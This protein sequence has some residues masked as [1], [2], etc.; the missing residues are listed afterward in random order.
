MRNSNVE[1]CCLTPLPKPSSLHIQSC[2]GTCVSCPIR[3]CLACQR[4]KMRFRFYIFA[5]LAQQASEE[6]TQVIVSLRYEASL[7]AVE[8]VLYVEGVPTWTA[9]GQVSYSLII[10]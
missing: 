2:L 1:K 8:C 5:D 10:P 4:Q 7:F 9:R 6:V 3:E